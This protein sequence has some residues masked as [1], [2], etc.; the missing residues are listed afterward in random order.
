MSRHVKKIK[1]KDK[2]SFKNFILLNSGTPSVRGQKCNNAL[3]PVS[4]NINILDFQVNIIRDVY[5]NHDIILTTGFDSD[6]SI[7]YVQEKYPHVKI[8]E[9]TSYETT[10]SCDTLRMALNCCD[11]H[12]TFIIHGDRIFNKEAIILNEENQAYVVSQGVDQKNYSYGISYSNDRL[13]NIS[14]GLKNIWS[15]ILYVPEE[16]LQY[17]KDYLNKRTPKYQSI[18]DAINNTKDSIKFKVHNNQSIKVKT[19]PR[20]KNEDFNI[21]SKTKS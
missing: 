16:H 4:K 12:D 19:I 18:G 2:L 6:N 20:K 11:L 21:Q 8:F 13:I 10:N 14:Y 17:F 7:K 1:R 5:A 15:E 3:F 9:N